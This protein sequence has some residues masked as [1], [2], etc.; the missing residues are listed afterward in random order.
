MDADTGAVKSPSRRIVGTPEPLPGV[1]YV[2]KEALSVLGESVVGT[3]NRMGQTVQNLAGSLIS[4]PAEIKER[5]IAAVEGRAPRLGVP[6]ISRKIIE[7]KDALA[8]VA[9]ACKLFQ[10]F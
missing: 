3:V 8:E 10:S 6:P 9:A 2:A 5:G 1:G 4:A 7:S